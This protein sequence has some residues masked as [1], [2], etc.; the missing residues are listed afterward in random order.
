MKTK[1]LKII[2]LT[3]IF[4]IVPMAGT[5][6]SAEDPRLKKDESWITISGIAAQVG[7]DTFLLDYGTGLITVEMDGLKWY[8]KDFKVIEGDRVTVRGKIDDDLFETTTIEADSVYDPKLG[9]FFY[10]SPR[11]EEVV[12]NLGHWRYYV[13]PEVKSDE[14]VVQGTVTGIDGREFT[15][16]AGKREVKINTLTMPYNPMD[17]KGF[18]VI[19]KNDL[20]RVRG[21]LMDYDF[22]K[23]RILYADSIVKIVNE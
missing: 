13:D 23:S 19:N 9:Q 21:N 3:V 11:D 14:I 5:S 10:A 18:Q 8:K 12:K 2:L 15:I 20:V 7:S 22:M 16:D 17:D 6:L 1:R 4:I